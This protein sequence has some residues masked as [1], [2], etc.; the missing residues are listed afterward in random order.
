MRSFITYSSPSIIRMMKS[1]RMRW[2]GLS[3]RMWEMRN[4]CRILVGKPERKKPLGK[5]GRRREDDI[6]MDLREINC[7]GIEWIDL[8]QDSD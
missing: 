3:A 6:K 7:S 4:V 5:R 8:A 2:S 1:R